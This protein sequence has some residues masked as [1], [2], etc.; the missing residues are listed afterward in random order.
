MTFTVLVMSEFKV[1]ALFSPITNKCLSNIKANKRNVVPRSS[2]FL[3]KN[4]ATR[5]SVPTSGTPDVSVTTSG[6]Q[7]GT[8]RCT[9]AS[10]PKP[11]LEAIDPFLALSLAPN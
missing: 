4:P 11:E 2:P 9:P 10:H 8:A 1:F 5:S 3:L 7:A 6:V